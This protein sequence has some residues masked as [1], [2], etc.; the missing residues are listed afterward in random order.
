[1]QG[2]SHDG[3]STSSPK[4]A[5]EAQ[6]SAPNVE[7][8]SVATEPLEQAQALASSDATALSAAEHGAIS[9]EDEEEAAELLEG[10]AISLRRAVLKS[11]GLCFPGASPPKRSLEGS[12]TAQCFTAR[13]VRGG[14]R[15][16]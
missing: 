7:A 12:P 11:L 6:P 14:L 3:A 8:A 15:T 1:M 2:P 10:I 16:C 4:P 13:P 5:A 9:V